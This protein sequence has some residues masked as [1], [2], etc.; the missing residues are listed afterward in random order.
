MNQNADMVGGRIT[1]N[2][3]ETP[4]FKALLEKSMEELR[5]KTMGHQG[6]DSERQPAGV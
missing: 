2:G 5:A 3:G 6:G 1:G 4:E